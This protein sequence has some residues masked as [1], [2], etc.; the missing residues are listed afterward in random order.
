[1]TPATPRRG[2]CAARRRPGTWRAAHLNCPSELPILPILPIRPI[3]PLESAPLVARAEQR[4]ATD[5][6]KRSDYL[7]ET[8]ITRL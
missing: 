4:R 8:C 1:M 7:V 6:T 3:R 5:V 2:D